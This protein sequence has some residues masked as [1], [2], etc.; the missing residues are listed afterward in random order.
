LIEWDDADLFSVGSDEANRAEMDL[1]VYTDFIVD[2]EL[3][4]GSEP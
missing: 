1:V 2:A 3:P 4:P